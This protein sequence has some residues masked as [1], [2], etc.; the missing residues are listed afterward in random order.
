MRERT[1]AEQEGEVEGEEVDSS[2]SREPDV[3]LNPR[4][5]PKADTFTNSAT[6]VPQ[7]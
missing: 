3:G 2:W 7:L 6:Q 1:H 5:E 4:T